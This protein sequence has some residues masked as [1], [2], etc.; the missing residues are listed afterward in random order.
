MRFFPKHEDFFEHFVKSAANTL[1]AAKFLSETLQAGP[2]DEVKLKILEEFEH[3]GDR[4]TH[5]TMERLNR[6][7]V[8]PIDREDIH[9]LVSRLDDVMDFIYS[10]AEAMSLYKIN[11]IPQS[12]KDLSRLLVQIIAEV[13]R[14]VERLS[15]LKRPEM[16]LAICIE[17]NRLENEVDNAHRRS[18]A[19]LFENEKDAFT[20]IKNKEILE[21]LETATDKCEDVANVIEGIVL[22][23]A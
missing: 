13:C 7:F 10:A 19:D 20:I 17:I 22:K 1:E 18:L 16:I 14:A 4:I 12:M 9:Q 3:K 21:D 8:T 15:N 6:T 2:I 5:D 11:P 23:N